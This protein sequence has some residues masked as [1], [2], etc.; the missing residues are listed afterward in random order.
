M[1][2]GKMGAVPEK[3]YANTQVRPLGS[4]LRGRCKFRNGLY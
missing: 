2:E 4:V 3:R 1:L